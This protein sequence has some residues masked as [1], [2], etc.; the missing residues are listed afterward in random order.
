MLAATDLHARLFHLVGGPPHATWRGPRAYVLDWP[1]MEPGISFIDL[2]GFTA[3]TEAHGDEE[4]ADLVERFVAMARAECAGEDRVV[5]SIGDAV[6]LHSASALTGVQLADRVMRSCAAEADFPM[7]RAGVHAGSVVERYGDVF[8]ATVNL[9]ARI[10]A[11]AHGGQLLVSQVVRNQLG[12]P[13]LSWVDLGDFE[14]RNVTDVVHLFE[15]S[16]GLDVGCIG[17]DPVCRMQVRRD[18]AGGRLR[19]EGTDYWL[20]SLECAARFAANPATYV[21]VPP[22]PGP[23]AVPST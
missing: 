18:R 2:A 12:D 23:V 8:G 4:A 7:A 10:A 13:A 5:K 19:Y 9:A 16:L 1:S 17:I 21:A 11:Q 22:T 14:L 3:L 15:L 20:C 6:L